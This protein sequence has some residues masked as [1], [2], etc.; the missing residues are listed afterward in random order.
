MDFD[1]TLIK[2]LPDLSRATLQR[3]VMLRPA[4]E[5]AR[6]SGI[7]YR[8]GFPLFATFWRAQHYITLRT[9]ADLPVLF[10]FME[11]DPV[12]VPDWLQLLP[13]LTGHPFSS[14]PWR[15]LLPRPQR[16][17]RRSPIASPEDSR[18]T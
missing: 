9:P 13:K 3:Q 2:I 4:L 6:Q 11:A 12:S 8:W 5:L 10:N 15:P 14:G 16:N 18:E 7:T 1:G 17:R